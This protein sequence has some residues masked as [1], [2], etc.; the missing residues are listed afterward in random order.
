MYFCFHQLYRLLNSSNGND[1][2]LTSCRARESVQLILAGNTGFYLWP[3]NILD[4]QQVDF[5]WKVSDESR[6]IC[7]IHT[8][9]NIASDLKQLVSL[10]HEN[11]SHK[12]I[13]KAVDQRKNSWVC[14]RWRK[15]SSWTSLN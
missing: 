3:P 12:N 15:T 1:A 7:T 2:I 13:D 10:T 9:L 11:I 6:N 8:S 5:G 14:T 4:Q